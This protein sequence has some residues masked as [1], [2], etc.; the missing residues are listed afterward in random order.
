MSR[1]ELRVVVLWGCVS[2]M[3]LERKGSSLYSTHR[4]PVHASCQVGKAI[5]IIAPGNRVDERRSCRA[6]LTFMHGS[7]ATAGL[8]CL[9]AGAVRRTM[10]SLLEPGA[11]CSVEVELKWHRN[12]GAALC[13]IG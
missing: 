1:F 6:D 11:I 3:S 5:R 8:L 13:N 12:E 7:T 10:I 2:V 9:G 4:M